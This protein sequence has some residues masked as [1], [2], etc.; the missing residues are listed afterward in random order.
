MHAKAP[1]NIPA[2]GSRPLPTGYDLTHYDLHMDT[3]VFNPKQ[4]YARAG[5]T[6]LATTSPITSVTLDLLKFTIDSVFA[7][8]YAV[9]RSYNDTLLTIQ[10]SPSVNTGDSV[11][12]WI[13]YHG[14]PQQDASGWGGFYFS[15]NFAFN[16][17]V[18]FMADPHN[19]GRA[20]F[21]CE[22]NF[23]SRARYDFHITTAAGSMA[24]CNGTLVQSVTNPNGTITRHWKQQQTIPSYLAS[25]AVGPYHSLER[26][27]NGLPVQWAAQPVDTNAVLAT[28]SNLDTTL[29]AYINAYG[30]YPFDKV[31]YCLV[32]FNSGAMEHAASIHIGRA[33]VNGTQTYAT[34]W[35]HELA[36]MWWGDKVTCE[37]A[38]DMW[39]NEG[40]AS[41]NEAFYTQNVSGVT[42]YRDWIRTNHRKVLQF[43]HTPAQDGSYLTMNQIPH[44]YTY[45]F[46]V[47]QKGADVVHT[48]RHY[49]G[50]QE[51]YTGCQY[52]MNNRAY[53]HANSTNLRDDL[54]TGSGVNMNRFFDDWIFTPGFPHFSIDSVIHVPG[55]LDHMFVYVRQRSRVTIT[56]MRCLLKLLLP[57][58]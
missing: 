33:F 27:S 54:T 11:L 56:S 39:L 35:A 52:Y 58:D 34:L 48:L 5:V 36:H 4:L 23:T 28:F 3:I 2:K 7:P 49:M 53:S 8:N 47:Y 6:F 37:T 43:A 19:F 31:G 30:A 40:F 17:G 44:A 29:A 25:M 14:E 51:F 42:A 55:G 16:L 21:P 38:E 12:V 9:T 24:F 32:P 1:N 57:M 41:Y 45:G 50:D 10:F 13:H 15:Q 18:G 26:T 20:W 46:H 22:D